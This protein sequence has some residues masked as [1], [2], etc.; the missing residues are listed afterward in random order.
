MQM[1]PFSV[2]KGLVMQPSELAYA[3]IMKFEFDGDVPPLEAYWD[4]WGGVW[5]IGWGHTR[6]AKQG[7]KITLDQAKELLH[8]DVEATAK[9]I[10]DYVRVGI[11]QEMFDAL[12]SF[13][14]N[15]GARAFQV[16]SLLRFLN[17]GDIQGAAD[18]FL[19]WTFS[20]HPKVKLQGLVARR[21]AERDLF[22][23]GSPR[24]TSKEAH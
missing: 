10:N 15:V 11:T 14:F 21:E 12:T 16:S 22:L 18:E 2:T 23:A 1:R 6:T 4:K 9:A 17:Q 20:G 5:T 8:Q 3:L 19:R 13:T 24:I 7:M